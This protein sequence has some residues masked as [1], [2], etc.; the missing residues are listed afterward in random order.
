MRVLP[1]RTPDDRIDGVV[2]TFLEITSRRTME[3]RVR[4]GEERL[5]LLIDAAVDYAIFTMS[6]DGRIDFWNPGAER[7]FGFRASEVI[8]KDFGVLFTPEDR[9]A[10]APAAELTRARDEGRALDERLHVRKDGSVMYCSGVTIRLGDGEGLGFAKIARDLTQ[11]RESEVELRRARAALEERVVARTSELQAEVNRRTAAQERATN[12]L[13]KLVT[14]QE[15][16]RARIARDLHDQLGQ[17]TTALRLTL[18]RYR[19]GTPRDM[20][21]I[22]RALAI[23]QQFD[24]ELDFLA[25][26]LRPAALG[27]LGLAA[28][29][30]QFVREWSALY[31]ITAE[32][33]SAGYAPGQLSQDVEVTF[34][35][36]AQE[37]L[38]NVAKHAHA[39]RV[40]VLLERRGD[41]VVLIVE[42]DGTGFDPTQ[43][44]TAPGIGLIGMRERAELSDAQLEIESAPGEGTTLFL[45]S[46]VRTLRADRELGP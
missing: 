18:E 31:G 26:E 22:D 7:M 38:N 36:I 6:D 39:S 2:I 15:D 23:I 8:G 27:D 46:Q 11:Q 44:A 5:R 25:W 24:R 14:A 10:G 17:Q 33:R 30:P 19:D 37:A 40:D 45:R 4:S 16:Q 1:Y 13:R 21:D 3:A 35:R 43:P 41:T 12:L 9:E 29:L 28:V 34:Y 32:F 20:G 42:D